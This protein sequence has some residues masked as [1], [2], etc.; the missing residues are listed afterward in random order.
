MVLLKDLI[1]QAKRE[2]R[3]EKKR[4]RSKDYYHENKNKKNK[5]NGKKMRKPLN[6]P[7][8]MMTTGFYA[9][10][11]SNCKRCSNGHIW[12][13]ND[14]VYRINRVDFFELKHEIERLGYKLV[15]FMDRNI[16][17][18]LSKENR[19]RVAMEGKAGVL[20]LELEEC[21]RELEDYKYLCKSLMGDM[22]DLSKPGV[23]ELL[24]ECLDEVLV[25][26]CLE[27]EKEIAY[28]KK[29]I[30]YLEYLE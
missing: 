21:K 20:E 9:V 3:L 29:R 16:F 10:Y 23:K 28:L 1:E 27:Q 5:K 24:L 17:N 14:G 8:Y 25:E 11:L 19:R 26:K 13:Y 22:L 6:K 15:L 7:K 30:T 2:Q 12:T 18:I 4:N